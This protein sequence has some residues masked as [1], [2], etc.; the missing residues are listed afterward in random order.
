[1]KIYE[2]DYLRLNYN[3][4]IGNGL[5]IGASFQFQNRSPLENLA[6]PV[7]WKDIADRSFTPNY[8]TELTGSNMPRNKASILSIGLT[9]RPGGD[10]VEFPDRKIGV[11]SKFPTFSASVTKGIHGLLGSDVDYTKW[12]IGV[13]DEMDLKL[14]GKFNYNVAA[15]GFFDAKKTF[16]PDYLHYQGNQTII[17]TRELNSYQLA[18]YYQYS[19]TSK[20]NLAAH[21]EYHM[22]GFLSNKIPGF[23]KLNWFFVTGANYLHI[24]KGTNYTEVFFGIENILKVIRIDYVTGFGPG[25]L[26]TNGIRLS[27]P[28][29]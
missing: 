14:A 9:W 1:M 16:I 3:T 2:A 17:A 12:R 6:D 7:S 24:D 13:R 20:F 15:S 5:N 26:R 29:F 23:K 21:A 11:G 19:N 18:P 25:G 10:Y 28:V 27:V 8:P 4:G 22:N